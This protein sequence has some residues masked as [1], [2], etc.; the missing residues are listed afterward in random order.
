MKL[1]SKN[2][3]ALLIVL[4]GLLSGCIQTQS[5]PSHARSGETIILGLGGIHRNAG[6]NYNLKK[7]DLSATLTDSSGIEHQLMVDALFK[8]YQ[9]HNSVLNMGTIT[10]VY[11]GM[12]FDVYDGGWFAAVSLTTASP[13]Q[14][15][16]IASGDATIRVDSTDLINTNYAPY[17]GD[18]LNIPIEIVEGEVEWDSDVLQQFNKYQSYENAFVVEPDDLAAV[19]EVAGAYLVIHYSDDSL[20]SREPIVIP[21]GHN[22][23]IQLA[24]NVVNHGDGTGSIYVTLM[25]PAGFKTREARIDNSSLLA[26]LSVRLQYFEVNGVDLNLLEGSFTLDQSASYYVDMQ[27]DA[28]F[29]IDP[30]MYSLRAQ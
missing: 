8:V 3:Y 28:I 2:S 30:L 20:L 12:D 6:S 18:L 26:D 24:Y 16:P 21:V 4:V 1:T 19:D 5:I 25:N 9:D 14:A 15:L 27:G 17:E 13:R 23:F 7:T 29:A 10:G 22:P 11:S